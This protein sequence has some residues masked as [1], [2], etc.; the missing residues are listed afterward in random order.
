MRE[1]M[2]QHQKEC[3]L[4][5]SALFHDDRPA[6]ARALRR[7]PHAPRVRHRARTARAVSTMRH[8]E[9]ESSE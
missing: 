4:I 5:F 9:R 8:S 6:G 3:S 7:A 1:S 2:P